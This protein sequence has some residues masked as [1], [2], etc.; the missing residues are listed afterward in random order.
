MG[1]R[2]SIWDAFHFKHPQTEDHTQP[3]CVYPSCFEFSVEKLH[4]GLLAIKQ[5][6][7]PSKYMLSKLSCATATP[8]PHAQKP[9]TKQLLEIFF[10]LADVRVCRKRAGVV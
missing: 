5:L 8:P 9:K 6:Y 4:A 2:L 3:S 1:S 10:I 7:L